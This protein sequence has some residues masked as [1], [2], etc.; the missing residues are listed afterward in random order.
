[1]ENPKPV[2][3]FG[4]S[5]P[6]YEFVP[7]AVARLAIQSWNAMEMFRLPRVSALLAGVSANR[8][9]LTI[10]SE[11]TVIS[12]A[13]NLDSPR[14]SHVDAAHEKHRAEISYIGQSIF[15]QVVEEE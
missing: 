15:G 6:R 13:P 7:A 4:A 12:Y 11:G 3:Y 9:R 10:P 1:M 8:T 5:L 14:E 2:G